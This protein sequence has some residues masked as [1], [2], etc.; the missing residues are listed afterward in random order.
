MSTAKEM[1]EV[2]E[3]V[4]RE[5]RRFGERLPEGFDIRV[6]R[7]VE[8]AVASARAAKRKPIPQASVSG[9]KA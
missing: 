3:A 1:R 2:L 9:S 5:F 7:Q 6:V 4:A 8:D